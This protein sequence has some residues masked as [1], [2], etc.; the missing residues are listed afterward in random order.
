MAQITLQGNPINTSGNL[1][2]IGSKASGFSLI[3]NDLSEKKLADYNGSK[4]VLN[5]FPSKKLLHWKTPKYCVFPEI[6]LLQWH[7][8]VELK[9]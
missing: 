6:Y 1:P 9:V 8:F 5:I 3:A 4:I 7:V 2:E